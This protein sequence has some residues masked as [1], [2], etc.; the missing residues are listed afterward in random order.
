[1]LDLITSIKATLYDRVYS[2]LSGTLIISSLVSNYQLTLLIFSSLSYEEKVI[3]INNK[4]SDS[5]YVLTHIIAYPILFSFFYFTLYPI[6]ENIVYS[7]HLKKNK[8]LADLRNKIEE[9]RLLTEKES[10]SILERV[11]AAEYNY[12]N[13]IKNKEEELKFLQK[14]VAFL[15]NENNQLTENK[16]TK[17]K[18]LLESKLTE[19]LKDENKRKILNLVFEHGKKNYNNIQGMS[20]SSIIEKMK[21]NEH[22]H[23]RAMLS[24][25]NNEDILIIYH[26][27]EKLYYL[28]HEGMVILDKKESIDNV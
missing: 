1:M 11:R 10:R 20:E 2:P 14:K 21:P 7:I 12:N 18:S 22:F 19:A 17:E 25:L 27:D 16:K 5:C 24:E 26:D 3:I 9:H 13:E 23:T 8:K 15:E 6:I 28:S 4:L